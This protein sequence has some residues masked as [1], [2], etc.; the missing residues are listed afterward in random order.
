MSEKKANK[1]INETSPYLL[2]HAYNPVKWY[3]W[4]EEAL[5]KAKTEDKPIIVSIGYS[6]CHWCHVMERESFENEDIGSMMSDNFVCIKV[7]REERPDVDQIYMDALHTMGLQ[8]GWPLN[9]FLT[10]DQKPFY[11]GTYFR[12][13]QWNQ[14]LNS[15]DEAFQK[16]RKKLN[17]SAEQFTSAVAKSDFEKYQLSNTDQSTEAS[18]FETIVAQLKESFDQENGGLGHAPKFPMPAIWDF[19]LQYSA[20]TKSVPALEMATLTLDKMA[21]G[22]IYDQIGGGFS[23]YSVDE[24]WFAPHFEKMLYDNGQLLSIYSKA[25]IQTNNPLHKKVVY[26]TVDFVERELVSP[27]GAFY[28]ALDADSEGEEGKFY[29]WTYNDFSEAVEEK[30]ELFRSYYSLTEKGNWEKG[31]N[32]LHS[33]VMADVFA[34]ENNLSKPEFVKSLTEVNKKLL[35]VRSKRIRPGLD[36]KTL[37]GWNALMTTG[38]LDAYNAFAEPKFMGM[39]LKNAKFIEEKLTKG[40][41]LLHTYKKGIAKLDGFLEDY[42]LVTQAYIS[43]Y[44]AT[45][46]DKWLT[47]AKKHSDYALENFYDKDEGFFYFTDKTSDQLITR[48]KELFDN[49][50]PSSNSIMGFN[51]FYLGLLLD[52]SQYSKLATSMASKVSALAIKEPRYLSNW[53]NLLLQIHSPTAE[54]CIVGAEA[55]EY[56][57][58]ITKQLSS[59]HVIVGTTT[60]S[61]LPL[62]VNRAS[63][64]GKT[65][66]Y[67]C[68]NKTCQLPVHTVKEALVQIKASYG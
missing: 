15:V 61:S 36:D 30:T 66:I 65:T 2:Q 23:R 34:Q 56:R 54:V 38:L 5:Q 16:N 48:K 12:P 13:D 29:T 52:E 25:F 18:D 53:A 1:L 27:E 20:E 39:A 57:K 50:I 4:G 3:P 62:L 28:S 68:F 49:V 45:F 41:K 67:V 24:R 44:Q 8:G 43:L 60:S 40:P 51:L 17:D 9:V 55:L 10:P 7:D 11:G 46:D 6:A 19:L 42:A 35:E 32:I 14:L 59:S 37:T 26:E 63:T 31:W 58:E 21:L 22:G 33:Q 47:K 64:N